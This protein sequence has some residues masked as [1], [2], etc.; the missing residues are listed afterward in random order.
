MASEDEKAREALKASLKLIQ[1]LD[2][3]ISSGEEHPAYAK[4]RADVI[5]GVITDEIP[6]VVMKIGR[7]LRYMQR[8]IDGYPTRDEAQ[9]AEIEADSLSVG[10]VVEAARHSPG[11]AAAMREAL[12]KLIRFTCNTCRERYCEDDAI[13]E[14]GMRMTFDCSIIREASAALT[15]PAR[16]CDVGTAE[17]QMK[18]QYDTMC[19][20]TNACP[21]S[22]WS[23]KECFAQWAQTPYEAEKGAG[24]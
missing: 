17:E 14:D 11:N 19:N 1:K 3:L 7:A 23:C 9:K 13:E 10:G 6:N 8:N 2:R 22:D 24:E 16:Q 12:E 5:S 18:R 4:L 21:D 20:T 15:V